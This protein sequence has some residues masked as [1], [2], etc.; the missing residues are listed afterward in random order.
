MKTQTRDLTTAAAVVVIGVRWRGDGEERE[1]GFG[2]RLVV[3][4]MKA[5]D[6]FFLSQASLS[7]GV[8]VLDFLSLC[9]RNG[10]LFCALI[11]LKSEIHVLLFWFL[12]SEILFLLFSFFPHFV[13]LRLLRP[14]IGPKPDPIWSSFHIRIWI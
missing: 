10:C 8:G 14:R 5:E 13:P 7:N 12:N 6:S 9:V 4:S 11:Y 2:L 3:A 1:G